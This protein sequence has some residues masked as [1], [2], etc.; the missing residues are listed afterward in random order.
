MR[1]LR[2]DA[3]RTASIHGETISRPLRLRMPRHQFPASQL[4]PEVPGVAFEDC[5]GAVDFGAPKL[6]VFVGDF[7]KVVE[8]VE[9]DVFDLFD[10]WFNVPREGEI[11]EEA[12]A[13]GPL[14]HG[15]RKVGLIQDRSGGGGR[16]D[17]DIEMRQLLGKVFKFD[18]RAAQRMG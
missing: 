6:E 18:G 15:W 10:V 13:L 5:A 2:S 16:A 3:V 7:G 17:D 11:D 14:F 8:V 9:I 4:E 12:G 1:N